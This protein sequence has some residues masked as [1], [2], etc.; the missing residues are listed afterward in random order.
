VKALDETSCAWLL[1]AALGTRLHIPILI[2][3]CTGLRRG[4][5]LAAG[6]SDLDRTLGVLTVRRALEETRVSGIRF[7]EP[8]NGQ[9]R[10][11]ALPP[12]ALEYLKL[13]EQRQIEI[14]DTIGDEYQNNGLI[15]GAENGA[16]WKPSAFTSAYR[17][18]LK[19]K[20]LSGP[21]FHAL[22]HS[23]AS[24]LLKEGIDIKMVSKRL[25]HSKT[26]FTLDTYAHI[27][28]G[29]DEEAARRVEAI[30]SRAIDGTRKPPV[31]KAP[32]AKR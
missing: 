18:L 6:W 16:V 26:A 23:H 5:I 12:V 22:R 31:L 14:R 28:P 9:I 30:L 19:R 11:V 29:Q 27:L 24:Q 20:N 2:A 25:G 32:L 21:N 13:H 15:C 3:I 1:D 7:K 10:K 17:D 4:E 8:K